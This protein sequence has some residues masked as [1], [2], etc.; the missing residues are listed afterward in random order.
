MEG[1]VS[2]SSCRR[3]GVR[4]EDMQV[5]PVMWPLGRAI[6]STIASAGSQEIMTIGMVVM[7]LRAACSP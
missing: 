6:R 4:S 2:L 1:T 7:A 3:L 5:T